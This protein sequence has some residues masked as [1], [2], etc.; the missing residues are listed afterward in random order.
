MDLP[1]LNAKDWDCWESPVARYLRVTI[2]LSA[3]AIGFLDR[4]GSLSADAGITVFVPINLLIVLISHV[5]IRISLNIS[6]ADCEFVFNYLD[7]QCV[8]I[9]VMVDMTKINLKITK[10]MTFNVSQH[11]VYPTFFNEVQGA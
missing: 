10:D 4:H 8:G 5:R 1:I 7:H 6:A 2:S 9:A 11:L 3:G